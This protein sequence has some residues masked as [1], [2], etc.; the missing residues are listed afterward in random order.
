MDEKNKNEK[1]EKN[2][3]RAR[4]FFLA[5]VICMACIAMLLGG[6][7][8]Y[9]R[10]KGNGAEEIR[11]ADPGDTERPTDVIGDVLAEEMQ[12]DTE[13]LSEG[14]AAADDTGMPYATVPI[15]T[16]DEYY[17]LGPSG[18]NDPNIDGQGIIGTWSEHELTMEEAGMLGLREI[19]RVFGDDVDYSQMY[20]TMMLQNAANR[21]DR[22][23]TWYGYMMDCVNGQTVEPG[24]QMRSYAF[25]IN[26]VTGEIG[27]LESS[28]DEREAEYAQQGLV[29]REELTDSAA[30][31]LRQLA[32]ADPSELTVDT[33]R[34]DWEGRD[35]SAVIYSRDGEFYLEILIW[36]YSGRLRGYRYHT[37]R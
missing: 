10:W 33:V 8:L 19:Y 14:T 23:D 18:N 27:L 5:G 28:V 35:G 15:L 2:Q 30:G 37:K 31:W 1:N 17:A 34:I 4:T 25:E 32:L 36:P 6:M 9:A 16:W 11:G 13:E 22:T 29:T 7:S 12:T 20:L 21:S 3:N 24:Y 26:A